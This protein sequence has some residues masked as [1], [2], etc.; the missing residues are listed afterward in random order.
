MIITQ[1]VVEMHQVQ[2]KSLRYNNDKEHKQVHMP[3]ID[4]DDDSVWVIWVTFCPGQTCS[5]KN[6]LGLTRIGSCEP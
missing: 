1:N 4:E 2:L 6:Y 3:A 5:V